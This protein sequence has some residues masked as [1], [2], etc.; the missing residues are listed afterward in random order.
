MISNKFLLTSAKG[1]TQVREY[2]R[3]KPIEKVRFIEECIDDFFVSRSFR[4]V[5]DGSKW[6]FGGVYGPNMHST[7]SVLCYELV[8]LYSWRHVP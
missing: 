6:A 5:E 2:T 3:E 1:T 4:N 7:G 8:G